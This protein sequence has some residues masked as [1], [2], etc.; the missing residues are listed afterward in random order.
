MAL[1]ISQIPN[2]AQHLLECGTEDCGGN[3]QFYC[4]P[5]LRPICDQCRDKHLQNPE[6]KNHEV[7]PYK[8]RRRHLPVEK[9]MVH[10]GEILDFHCK[11]CNVPLCSK[12]LTN[13]SHQ[14]HTFF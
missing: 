2:T 1:S 5:C 14:G 13:P 6:S 11:E 7:V 8:Q 10:S 4:N 3:C 12:C 9:C